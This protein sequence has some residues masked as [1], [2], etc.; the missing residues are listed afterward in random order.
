MILFTFVNNTYLPA[1]EASIVRLLNDNWEFE[2]PLTVAHLD[3]DGPLFIQPMSSGRYDEMTLRWD[4]AN[5]VGLAHLAF[6][7]DDAQFGREVRALYHNLQLITQPE[8]NPT[9]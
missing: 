1:L 7:E 9:P 4:F 6:P 2:G 8:R 5:R 3:R